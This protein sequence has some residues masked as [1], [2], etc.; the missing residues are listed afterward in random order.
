MG[1]LQKVTHSLQSFGLNSSASAHEMIL[2]YNAQSDVFKVLSALTELYQVMF[3][4]GSVLRGYKSP[5]LHL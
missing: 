1:V 2:L 5:R 4:G 3:S